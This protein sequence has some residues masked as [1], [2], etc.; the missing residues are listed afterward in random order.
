[1][2]LS[3]LV[4]DLNNILTELSRRGEDPIVFALGFGP[5]W[6]ATGAERV[7]EVEENQGLVYMRTEK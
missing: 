5:G 4:R 6:A 1:M 7:V 2:K 3:E